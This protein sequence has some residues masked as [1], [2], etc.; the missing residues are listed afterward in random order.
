MQRENRKITKKIPYQEKHRECG[1]FAKTQGILFAQVVN[2]LILKVKNIVILV[3]I[4]SMF[5]LEARYICQVSFVYVLVTNHVNWHREH[6][7]YDRENT[8]N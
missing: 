1:N 5:F 8:G 2:S 6:F 4:N 3:A 7:L